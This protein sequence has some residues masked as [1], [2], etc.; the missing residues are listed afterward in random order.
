MPTPPPTYNGCCVA[1]DFLLTWWTSYH[2]YPVRA[3]KQDGKC[4]LKRHFKV[5][6]YLN[7][8]ENETT[9]DRFFIIV[10]NKKNSRKVLLSHLAKIPDNLQFCGKIFEE[11]Y[12]N[13]IGEIESHLTIASIYHSFKCQNL[14]QFLFT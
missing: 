12:Y 10:I 11:E 3:K 8:H 1:K 7:S 4:V 14:R 5:A 6:Q 13:W 2:D 9:L